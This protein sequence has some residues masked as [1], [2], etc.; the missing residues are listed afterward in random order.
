MSVTYGGRSV[1]FFSHHGLL[2]F[3]HSQTRFHAAHRCLQVLELRGGKDGGEDEREEDGVEDESE[4]EDEDED[5]VEDE[6][7]YEDEDGVDD[8]DGVEVDGVEVED[9]VEDEG[10]DQGEEE[11]ENEDG[12]EEE[13]VTCMFISYHWI[14]ACVDII[15]WCSSSG[16]K[17]EA[18]DAYHVFK[19]H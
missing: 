5:G 14:R 19:L 11:D 15:L 6:R 13:E 18:V 1:H 3:A 16:D 4:D 12:I 10:E 2:L 7:E 17:K 8:E 9:G